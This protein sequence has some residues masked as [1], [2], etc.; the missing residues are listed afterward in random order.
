MKIAMHEITTRDGGF[1]DHLKAY[2]ATGWRHFEINLW[3]AGE[4]LERDG[5]A[6][7]A[8]RVRDAGLTCVGATGHAFKAF[9]TP[10]ERAKDLDAIRRCGETMQAL[11]CSALVVGG[12]TPKDLD[13][14]R[15]G[16]YLERYAE[17]LRSAAEAGRPYGV[18]L[19]VEVN[20]TGLCR[21]FRTARKLVE[22]A[23]DPNVGLVW[24]PAHF[25]STPSRVED[26]AA[27][28]GLFR[29]AHLNDIREVCWEAL[30]VNADRVIPGEGVLPLRAWTDAVSAAG[31]AGWHCVELFN[32]ALW[33]EDLETICKRVMDGCR[34]VWPEAEF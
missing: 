6:A 32:E 34:R 14:S 10:E 5:A 12:D 26:L 29:H 31:Y 9:G 33:R 1:D 22:R 3:K 2:A 15:Y 27:C 23:A 11:G 17:H 20:W 18:A 16:E 30:N 19:C 7:V 24:D 28:R 13:K 4:T 25:V 21:S 8:R